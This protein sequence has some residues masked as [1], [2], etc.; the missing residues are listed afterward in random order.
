MAMSMSVS[1]TKGSTNTANNTS[2]ATLT[3]KMTT[4]YGSYNYNGM[5][6][7]IKVS[8]NASYS[9]NQTWTIGLTTTKTM[10]TRTFTLNHDDDG[11]AKVTAKVTCDTQVSSGTLTK[12]VS[13]TAPTIARASEP[14]VTS[15]TKYLG[16]AI[17]IST[18]RKSSTFTHILKWNWAGKSGTIASNVGASYSWTP[19]IATFAPYLTDATSDNCKITCE[20]YDNND[21]KIGSKTTSFTLAIPT[22]VVPT[23][24]SVTCSDGNGY[25]G[26]YGAYVQS[27]SDVKATVTATGIYGSTISSYTVTLDDVT[28]NNESN[29]VDIGIPYNTGSRTV[30]AKVVDSRGRTATKTT[31]ITVAAYSAPDIS[32]SWAKRWNTSTGQ[33]DDESSTVRVHAQGSVAN[34]NS[35][36]LNQ[37]TVKIEYQL[38]S[39]SAWTQKSNTTYATSWN[40]NT[41]IANL[42][43]N[44]VY[45]VRV[46]VTDSLGTVST[47]TY[48][49][50]TAKPILDFLYNGTG[51]A[52]GRVSNLSDVLDV[53][54]KIKQHQPGYFTTLPGTSSTAG[55]VRICRI[56]NTAYYANSSIGFVISNRNTTPTTV[57]MFFTNSATTDLV[58]KNAYSIG[59]AGVYYVCSGNTFDL[60]VQKTE[61]YDHVALLD[62]IANPVHLSGF[63]WDLEGL[64]SATL[65]S[66]AVQITPWFQ[67]QATDSDRI[68]VSNHMAL[69]NGI[70]LQGA[71]ASGT[72][73]NILGMNSSDQVELNWTTGGLKGRV[74]KQLWSGT[75][76]NGG[77]ITVS[78]I[79]Y[80]N[81][82]L[83]GVATTDTTIIA[84]RD[85]DNDKALRGVNL[86]AYTST[87]GSP[88]YLIY[89]VDV[90]ISGT[91][92]TFARI[93]QLSIYANG[94]SG[95]VTY[96]NN[97][98]CQINRIYGLL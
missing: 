67:P 41:D 69:D 8:G 54:Y 49:I 34:V 71:L 55:Y 73:T 31:T 89:A 95:N 44:N 80:Y 70:Y 46:T 22:T 83:L 53:Q 59:P 78:E 4:T 91:S 39:A 45:R 50:E 32:A 28:A 15:G 14:S 51:M 94:S 5:P 60:W 77:K 19:A 13:Y 18:N 88:A 63:A 47:Q 23:L 3:V 11:T 43:T 84:T 56:T 27:K 24:S 35:K 64:F 10:F 37:G 16:S 82:F 62:I 36:G 87:N 90:D 92:L 33:E 21:N 42:S 20:T 74:R 68:L 48:V 26:T 79:G 76:S 25:L 30:T 66:G 65:P 38:S 2:T 96:A 72:K 97:Q 81:V 52:V 58:V 6:A 85:A 7:T 9:A 75:V 12:T 57:N 1:W 98:A 93:W 17:P 29:V 40:F 86:Q 61:S